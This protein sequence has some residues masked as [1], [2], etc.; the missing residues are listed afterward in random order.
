MASLSEILQK[1]FPKITH[2]VSAR[3]QVEKVGAGLKLDA[4]G[5]L[6][7]GARTDHTQVQTRIIGNPADLQPLFGQGSS[8][9]I[10]AADGKGERSRARINL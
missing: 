10:T 6:A 5:R 1:I 3:M 8:F 9:E 4:Q 7:G 2:G